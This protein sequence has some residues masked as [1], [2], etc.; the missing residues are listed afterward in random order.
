MATFTIS[1]SGSA[2]VNGSKSWT[3]SDADVQKL[4]TFTLA[5]YAAAGSSI[6]A[7]QALGLWTQ[8]FVNRTISD[9]GEHQRAIASVPPV[10]FT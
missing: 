3:L 4:S 8:D 7:A 1:L 9:V 10:V 6:T 5:K 2:I